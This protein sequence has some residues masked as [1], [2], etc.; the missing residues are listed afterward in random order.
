MP[1]TSFMAWS[2]C[3]RTNRRQR[4]AATGIAQFSWPAGGARLPTPAIIGFQPGMPAAQPA[5]GFRPPA[6]AG[7]EAVFTTLPFASTIWIGSVGPL[8]LR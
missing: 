7:A 1:I 8:G 4:S 3:L 5:Y 6:T 2:P